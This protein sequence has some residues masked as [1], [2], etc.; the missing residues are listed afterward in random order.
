MHRVQLRPKAPAA[1]R[2][3]HVAFSRVRVQAKHD[4]RCGKMEKAEGMAEN[5][6]A[7]GKKCTQP[8][9]GRWRFQAQD[10]LAGLGSGQGMA[11]R[12]DAANAGS[13][14]RHLPE[15]ATDTEGFESAEFLDLQ[16]CMFHL[17]GIVTPE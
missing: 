9:S 3:R 6:L 16:A 5:N 17:S 8:V 7:Q 13:N 4:V 12:A 14:V 15:G 2:L 11:D 10:T 1:R